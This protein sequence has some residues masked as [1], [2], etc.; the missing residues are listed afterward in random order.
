[1]PSKP[2]LSRFSSPLVPSVGCGSG[3]AFG[4]PHRPP[5]AW[6][7]VPPLEGPFMPP[8]PLEG[9][10]PGVISVSIGWSRSVGGDVCGADGDYS[11]LVCTVR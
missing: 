6:M 8:P 9:T 7:T 2:Q 11:G 1:M 10:A 4:L 5:V 3:L